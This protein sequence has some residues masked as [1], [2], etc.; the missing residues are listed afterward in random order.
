ME[1]MHAAVGHLR[2][3]L[4]D[5]RG[6]QVEAALEVGEARLALDPECV[7]PDHLADRIAVASIAVMDHRAAASPCQ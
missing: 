6:E 1:S 3:R 7:R 5:V 2:G 4:G